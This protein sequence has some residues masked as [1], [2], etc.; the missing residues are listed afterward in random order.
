MDSGCGVC[1]YVRTSV[2]FYHKKMRT[3]AVLLAYVR[4]I[5]CVHRQDQLRTSACKIVDVRTENVLILRIRIVFSGV[6]NFL[7]GRQ[8]LNM[9]AFT[10]FFF[11]GH[12]QYQLQT[13]LRT[14]AC[15]TADIHTQQHN[16]GRPH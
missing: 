12:P 16:C 6:L 9:R 1:M 13:E 11:C 2:I 8:Q 15:L 14:S 4:R 5:N 3:S 10:V 7:C